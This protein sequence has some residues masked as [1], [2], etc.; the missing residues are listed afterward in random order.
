MSSCNPMRNLRIVSGHRPDMGQGSSTSKCEHI[1][2][3]RS[4]SDK[5][6]QHPPNPYNSYQLQDIPSKFKHTR[7][8]SINLKQMKTTSSKWHGVVAKVQALYLTYVFCRGSAET[9]QDMQ[10]LRQSHSA[11]PRNCLLA[12]LLWSLEMSGRA[13]LPRVES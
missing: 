12:C 6:E 13:H 5:F 11:Q 9:F 4:T 1:R 3:N 2:A 8:V 7:S 10:D